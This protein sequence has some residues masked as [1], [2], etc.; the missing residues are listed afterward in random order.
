MTISGLS[1]SNRSPRK[2]I[3]EQ[4]Y[5]I[6][7]MTSKLQELFLPSSSLFLRNL[8]TSGNIKLH[9]S[10]RKLKS[11]KRPGSLLPNKIGKEK[12]DD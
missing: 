11:I 7:Y 8:C 12:I 9:F 4:F 6:L 3:K 5:A 1:G 10:T 2:H